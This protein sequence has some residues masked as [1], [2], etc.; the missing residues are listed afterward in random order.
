[1]TREMCKMGRR[2]WEAYQGTE[3]D[4]VV[5][6]AKSAALGEAALRAHCIWESCIVS[7]AFLSKTEHRD[8]TSAMSNQEVIESMKHT[9][10]YN[11]NRSMHLLAHNTCTNTTSTITPLVSLSPS[12]LQLVPSIVRLEQPVSLIVCS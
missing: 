7:T 9:F 1:M 5:I 2:R 11:M 10:L 12:H 6:K 3:N 8:R 4:H